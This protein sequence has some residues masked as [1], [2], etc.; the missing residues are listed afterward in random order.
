MQYKKDPRFDPEWRDDVF[1][2]YALEIP[3]VL[4][5][6]TEI[7]DGL[8]VKKQLKRGEFVFGKEF[9]YDSPRWITAIAKRSELTK[10]YTTRDESGNI[11]PPDHP[12]NDIFFPPEAWMTDQAEERC[13][14]LSAAKIAR[15]KVLSGGLGLAIYPQFI[16][17]LKRPVSSITIIECHPKIIQLIE[18]TWLKTLDDEERNKIKIIESTIEEYLKNSQ[19]IFDTIHLD[20]WEDADPRFLANV[21]YLIQLALPRCASDGQIQCWGYAQMVDTFVK[22]A[23]GLAEHSFPLDEYHLDPT[24]ERYWE[25]LNEQQEPTP[26]EIEQAARKFALTTVKRLEEYVVERHRCFSNL[27]MS[28]MD[29]YKSMALSRKGE[30]LEVSQ[31]SKI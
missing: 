11:L 27:G 4:P 24:L 29:A 13:T 1:D 18:D 10:Y 16:L 26:E 25:W 19:E 7:E 30:N 6:E 23:K 20:T 9:E 17:H 5:E 12:I 21:N 8:W 15:G 28:F 3:L 31:T 2:P 14:I 22:N